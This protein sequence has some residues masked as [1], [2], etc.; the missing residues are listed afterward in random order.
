MFLSLHRVDS[1]EAPVCS[2]LMGEDRKYFDTNCKLCVVAVCDN[3]VDGSTSP[4]L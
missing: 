4:P 2:H 3:M 1:G